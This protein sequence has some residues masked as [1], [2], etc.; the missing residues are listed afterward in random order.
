MISVHLG[1]TLLLIVVVP[2]IVGLACFKIG[3]EHMI[4]V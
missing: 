1:K 4:A 2:V 3:Y